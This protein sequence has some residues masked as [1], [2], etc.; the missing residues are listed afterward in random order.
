MCLIFFAWLFARCFALTQT[1]KS[2]SLDHEDFKVV[3]EPLVR[4]DL[5][6]LH[7]LKC[8]IELVQDDNAPEI[9]YPDRPC[10]ETSVLTASKGMGSRN[11]FAKQYQ[12]NVP[13]NTRATRA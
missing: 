2:S 4:V 9:D 11:N 7:G 13:K 5:S 3:V 12:A 6:R 1:T 10:R 8:E